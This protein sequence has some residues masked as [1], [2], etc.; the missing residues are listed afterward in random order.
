MMDVRVQ[1]A[2]L[3]KVM[4]LQAFMHTGVPS[5]ETFHKFAAETQEEMRAIVVD[6]KRLVAGYED[7]KQGQ[8]AM[9]AQ[10]EREAEGMRQLLAAILKTNQE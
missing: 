8:E 2:D 7:F 4:E 3:N 1:K 9:W 5:N 10:R 6:H